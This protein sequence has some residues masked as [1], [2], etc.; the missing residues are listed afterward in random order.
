[1]WEEASEAG[2]A[3]LRLDMFLFLLKKAEGVVDLKISVKGEH[4]L[5]SSGIPD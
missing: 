1:M 5:R 2:G 4:L 3:S